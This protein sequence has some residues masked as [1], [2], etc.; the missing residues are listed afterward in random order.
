[1]SDPTKP[2]SGW[3][4]LCRVTLRFIW[5][6]L[7]LYIGWFLWRSASVD[8]WGLWVIGGLCLLGGGVSM[9]ASLFRF[10]VLILNQ[11]GWR[12]FR[13]LGAKPKADTLTQ[14]RDLIDHTRL[15]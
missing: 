1:M 2:N 12:G 9:I 5:A 8:W 10:G 3:V 13:K 6:C 15:P 11:R 4:A 14:D 7:T